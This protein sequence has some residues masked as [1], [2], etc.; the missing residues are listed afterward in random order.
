MLRNIRNG[1]ESIFCCLLLV[2]VAGLAAHTEDIKKV[3]M[4]L[5]LSKKY[6]L[7]KSVWTAGCR[8]ERTNQVAI[9]QGGSECSS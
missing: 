1:R 9:K 2:V 4:K 3:V 8:K 5:V 6:R 7:S